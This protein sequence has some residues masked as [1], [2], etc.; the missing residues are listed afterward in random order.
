[1]A[2]LGILSGLI[3]P[4]SSA[5]VGLIAPEGLEKYVLDSII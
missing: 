5:L 3:F 1:M 4:A 2:L